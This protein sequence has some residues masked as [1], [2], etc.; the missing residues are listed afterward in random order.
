MNCWTEAIALKIMTQ[1][2]DNQKQKKKE[3]LTRESKQRKNYS[4]Q[5]NNRNLI[6]KSNLIALPFEPRLII[7]KEKK[8]YIREFQLCIGAKKKQ[9]EE[10][11]KHLL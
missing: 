1:N 8:S 9:R 2:I 3:N 6:K 4:K 7:K 5:E 10:G 11:I